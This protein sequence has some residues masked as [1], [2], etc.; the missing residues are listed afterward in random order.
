MKQKKSGDKIQNWHRPLGKSGF[1][2]R[3]LQRRHDDPGAQIDT[4][5][6]ARVEDVRFLRNQREVDQWWNC[7]DPYIGYRRDWEDD[8]DYGDEREPSK[9]SDLVKYHIT[10]FFRDKA[11]PNAPLFPPEL[12]ST[13]DLQN[14]PLE[15]LSSELADN[16]AL[17]IWE[18]THR[19]SD[20]SKNVRFFED[21]FQKRVNAQDLVDLQQ[22]D[23]LKPK[24]CKLRETLIFLAPFWI[25]RPGAWDQKGGEQQLIEHLLVRYEVPPFLWIIWQ[26]NENY[27]DEYDVCVNGDLDQRLK[28]LIWFL[29]LAQG[30]SLKRAAAQ[31]EWAIYDKFQHYLNDAP[32]GVSPLEACIIAEVHRLGGNEID[33][34]R[35]LGCHA[36]V[37]DPTD[38]SRPSYTCFWYETVAWMISKRDQ[39]TDEQCSQLLDWAMHLHTEAEQ[40]YTHQQYFT[41]KGRQ[42]RSV[43]EQS[44][45]YHA[46]IRSGNAYRPNYRWDSHGWNWQYRDFAGLQWKFVELLSSRELQ[47]E[48]MA[49]RHCVG[50]Y[51]G[52]CVA[53]ASAIVSLRQGENRRLTIEIAPRVLKI[54]QARG[55]RNRSETREE[56]TVIRAWLD[57]L[58]GL[59]PLV[60]RID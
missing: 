32:L 10:S 14:N 36:Y 15:E 18:Y 37:V 58:Q 52:R 20:F 60:D 13:S 6:L 35:I 55:E 25:R 47:D 57:Y 4:N 54:V 27:V 51:D 11:C 12:A 23:F 1:S 59:R 30:G 28:W 26:I 43:I 2:W 8:D 44:T 16:L 29:L 5:D 40:G 17:R 19:L 3:Y 33:Y 41:W 38:I 31:F 48:G 45:E 34:R 46:R 53:G 24:Y 49:M 9:W 21:E 50:G 56:A 22:I 39:L 42:V 7:Y